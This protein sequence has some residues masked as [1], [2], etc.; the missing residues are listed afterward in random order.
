VIA[1]GLRHLLRGA[2]C[3]CELTTPLAAVRLPIR[4]VREAR[5]A[6]GQMRPL[7]AQAQGAAERG[8]IVAQAAERSTEAP[9]PV[10]IALR[11]GPPPIRRPG[12]IRAH[13]VLCGCLL[14]DAMVTAYQL[15]DGNPLIDSVAV[16]V[17]LACLLAAVWALVAQNGTN[18]GR[19]FAWFGAG[20][21]G[22]QVALFFATWVVVFA[23]LVRQSM[24]TPGAPPE[25]SG[26]L[27]ASAALTT[28]GPWEIA[29]QSILALWGLVLVL[30]W[31]RSRESRWNS[32][33]T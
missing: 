5:R 20:A 24:L 19:S 29:V 22:A 8:A 2:T 33:T 3:S 17:F 4:R 32:L 30:H 21:L 23:T 26:R 27:F 11:P 16:V 13:A 7:I 1:C 10:P 14:L 28:L 12:T 15:P 18:L 31:R 6:I 9:P 25:L